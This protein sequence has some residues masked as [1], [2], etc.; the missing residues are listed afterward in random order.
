MYYVYMYLDPRKTEYTLEDG[1][2]LEHEPFY[3]GKGKGKRAWCHLDPNERTNNS[4]KKGKIKRITDAGY[5]PKIVFLH[6]GLTEIESLR[7]E[8]E[9]IL[10]IGTKWCIKGIA[11]GPLCNMTSGGDG[12]TPSDELKARFSMPG[13][14]NPMYGKTHSEEARKKISE[15]SKKLRHSDTTK[16]RMRAI[17]GPGGHDFR[18]QQWTVIYPNGTTVE[19]DHLRAF[20][21]KEKLPY[22][23]LYGS[24]VRKKPIT[25]GRN[26]GFQLVPRPPLA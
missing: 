17:R 11:S 25:S 14:K 6:E 26:K 8:E 4:L 2:R 15:Q 13:E 21:E 19:V 9:W 7:L 1:T 23:S 5:I 3:V 16:D 24:F 18:G 12:R 20:C 22:G 10:K